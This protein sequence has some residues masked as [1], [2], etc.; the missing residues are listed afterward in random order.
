VLYQ[1]AS[2]YVLMVFAILVL[3]LPSPHKLLKLIAAIGSASSISLLGT[4]GPRAFSWVFYGRYTSSRMFNGDL[5]WRGWEGLHFS[6]AYFVLIG[7]MPLLLVALVSSQRQASWFTGSG[8]PEP[9]AETDVT[10]H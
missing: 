10:Q 3:A 9:S 4:R 5:Y 7:V 8:Q 6:F 1:I 2:I